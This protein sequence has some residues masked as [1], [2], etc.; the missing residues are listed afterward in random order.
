DLHEQNQ[1]FEQIAGYYASGFSVGSEGESI[2]SVGVHVTANFFDTLGVRPVEGRG[3]VTG[4][5]QPGRGQVVVL[6]QRLWQRVFG[7]NP[8]AIGQTITLNGQS[9][10][11]IGVLPASFRFPREAELFV[12]VPFG[13]RFTSMRGLR[14][15][16][17]LARLKPGID[18]EQARQDLGAIASRLQKQYPETNRDWSVAPVSLHEQI[19]QPAR[20][21]LRILMGAV[22]LVLLI[23]CANVG[24]LLLARG[25]AR[26]QELAV[27]AALGAGR[28]RLIR[29]LLTESALLAFAGGGV[30][31]WLASQGTATLTTLAGPDLPRVHEIKLDSAVLV[32]TIS[33]AIFTSLVFGLAPAL[34]GSKPNLN[35][36]L[37]AGAR[38][39]TGD[40]GGRRLL[41]GL[42]TAEMALSLILLTG[43]GLLLRSFVKLRTVDTGFAPDHMLTAGVNLHLSQ[44]PQR[45]QRVGFWDQVIQ[46]VEA[47]PGAQSVATALVLPIDEPSGVNDF[48]IEG[49]PSAEFGQ[50]SLHAVSANYFRTLGVALRQGRDFT[51]REAVE[52]SPV[53]II[54]EALLRRHFPNQNPI[55][56]RLSFNLAGQRVAEIVG[57]AGDI[58]SEGLAVEAIPIIYFPDLMLARNLV[59]RTSVE[60][61]TLAPAVRKE[62]ALVDRKPAIAEVKT[63]EQRLSDSVTQPRFY[64]ALLGLFALLA[65]AL[66]V[67]GIYSVMS[68]SVTQRAHEMGLRL[69]LGA[70][71]GDVRRLVITQ[72]MKPALF[73]VALGAAAAFALTRLL[74]NMLFGVSATDPL[75]FI[76]IALSLTSVALVACWIQA[77]RATRVDPLIALRRE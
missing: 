27:R 60:P 51:G 35:E 7:G 18:V 54:N 42:I 59:V 4:E 55:G 6:T 53:A 38:R 62:I 14:M 65:L 37:K 70:Q 69:A 49:Q 33:L 20:P 10:T 2:W 1:V 16:Q 12:P 61:L 58:R 30:G 25:V 28:V 3:F 19:A 31:W 67:V 11:V 29:Q 24:A 63:M 74:K 71:A 64:L 46:R 56:Q 40:S 41:R 44:Y 66:S 26:Q 15:M 52:A 17:P 8:Q 21:A 34:A 48:R 57:V 75:T 22:L 76:G 73:G 32:F 43:A 23:A 45:Q 36:A 72:G 5:G 77:R 50:A 13:S 68:F 39:V 47:L 9:H